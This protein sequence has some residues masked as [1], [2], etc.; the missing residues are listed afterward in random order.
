MLDTLCDAILDTLRA[1]P[2]VGTC[3]MYAGQVG[4]D[5]QVGKS[6]RTPALLLRLARLEPGQ[7]PGTGQFGAT[8][9]CSL[10]VIGRN[11]RGAEARGR[12]IA[13]LV[14]YLLPRIR[15]ARWGL[16]G[17]VGCAELLRAVPHYLLESKGF[18]LWE[19]EF[20]HWLA[21]G[22]PVWDGEPWIPEVVW[23]GLEPLLGPAHVGDY[24]QVHP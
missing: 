8:A 10:Y 1:T 4:E 3:E 2:G 11:A 16:S 14:E 24:E 9:H 23:V 5:G 6:V 20:T 12:D 21:L 19:I 22:E 13:A 18:G 7:D 15:L 17:A